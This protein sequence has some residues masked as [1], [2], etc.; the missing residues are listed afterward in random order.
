MCVDS[1]IA[2][3]HIYTRTGVYIHRH[4]ESLSFN[5]GLH[6]SFHHLFVL[7]RAPPTPYS[8]AHTHMLYLFSRALCPLTSSTSMTAL[9]RS[10]TRQ[11]GA[12]KFLT[13]G[14]SQGGFGRC[15]TSCLIPAALPRAS[16]ML[17]DG[18]VGTGALRLL[19]GAGWLHAA[20]NTTT[21]NISF[22]IEAWIY[23]PGA[24]CASAANVQFMLASADYAVA[25]RKIEANISWP[26]LFWT[27]AP[28]RQ[29]VAGP[30]ML[31]AS[32]GVIGD[33]PGS[34]TRFDHQGPESCS[35]ILAPGGSDGGF[36]D[37]TLVFTEFLLTGEDL[38]YVALY[39][40]FDINCTS[41]LELVRFKDATLP[42]PFVSTTPV[43]K[44]VLQKK[45]LG[46]GIQTSAGFTA[47]Y[48]GTRMLPSASAGLADNA[49]HHIALSVKE[50]GRLSLIINGTQQLDQILTW[51]PT[52]TQS[53]LTR[54][55]DATAIGRGAPVWQNGG[56]FGH[57]CIVV[58][59][60]RFWTASRTASDV[61]NDMYMGCQ[62]VAATAAGHTLAACYSFDKTRVVD[63]GGESGNFFPDASQNQIS[64]FIANGSSHL[65]WCVN[66]DDG[67]DLKVGPSPV[68]DWSANKMWGF[69]TS[70]P[71]LPGAGFDYSEAAIEVAAA[72][73]LE[74]TA[75]VLELYP[76]C[77]DV[78]LR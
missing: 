77:G 47:S 3:G 56:D 43:M 26:L 78:P 24:E 1:L 14:N 57:A 25:L 59:E 34:L 49:W 74:G 51:D 52:P 64:A 21:N 42:P 13:G 19:P 9:L 38:E 45:H 39:S 11:S 65:P 41:W 69:C 33:G 67:G 61:S 60:L 75:A 72:R 46:G 54:G 62:A 2:A 7:S 73:R 36:R 76:G 63:G 31:T 35:W 16:S 70:K 23:V 50:T 66:V 55:K 32:T 8:L 30:Q 29:C 44:V 15:N 28:T 5:S 17:G 68:V 20:I 48:A 22:T 53:P 58:D 37:V 27:A 6:Y 4:A 10:S 71:F 40:C 12:P 18:I